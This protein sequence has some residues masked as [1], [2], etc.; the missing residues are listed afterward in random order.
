[1]AKKSDKAGRRAHGS[2]SVY[3]RKDGVW[4]ASID[5]G[6]VS[7]KRKR[8]YLYAST[9]D[10]VVRKMNENLGR[11]H[12]GINI[13]PDRITVEDYLKQWLEES[14]RPSVRIRTFESY[15]S[16]VDLHLIPSVGRHQLAKLTPRHVQAMLT[17]KSRAGL[18]PRTVAYIRTVL[19][20]A[21]ARAERWELVHRNVAELV[22]PPKQI[23]TEVKPWSPDEAQRFLEA[24][25]DHRLGA[26]FSVALALGLRKGEALGLRWSD[27]DLDA[28]RLTIAQQLQRTKDLGLIFLPPKTDR[29]R[30]TIMLPE[31][32]ILAINRHRRRQIRDQL[33]AG[34]RWVNSGLVFTTPI[35]TPL[36]PGN[37]NKL[38]NQLVADAGLR[39]Q[40]F[41]DQR[42][43]CASLLLAQGL[44]AVMVRDLLGHTQ[45]STTTD[46]YGHVIEE[47]LAATASAMEAVLSRKTG[48]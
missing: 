35:G 47:Q 15:R 6:Y 12:R 28:R 3:Q 43:W 42:H 44:P 40:R 21:L 11:L 34:A 20:I 5:L 17:E 30:R 19:R 16:I 31:T 38:F 25:S 45:L 9:Q 8:K 46:L 10:G 27:I 14:V 22:D 32:T 41:H 24:V 33:K 13:A 2:G 23:R 36:D 18:S 26:L 7:G 48:A 29:S 39:K 4:V 37:V 1:M